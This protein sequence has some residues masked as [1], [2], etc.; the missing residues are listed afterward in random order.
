MLA[1]VKLNRAQRL[2]ENASDQ[3]EIEE[4]EVA[5]SSHLLY[6]RFASFATVPG[7]RLL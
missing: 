5:S 4:L 3:A 1:I 7:N 6:V 2:D